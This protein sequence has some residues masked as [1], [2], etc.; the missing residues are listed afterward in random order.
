MTERDSKIRLLNIQ[1]E[2]L[3]LHLQEIYPNIPLDICIVLRDFLLGLFP[4]HNDFFSKEK[5]QLASK[6]QN[7]VLDKL[8]LWFESLTQSEKSEIVRLTDINK[9]YIALS[10][11][12]PKKIDG[13]FIIPDQ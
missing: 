4:T 2:Q 11:Q 7:E 10:D 8:D 12:L 6:T 13:I 9:Q 3:A 1:G 5:Q